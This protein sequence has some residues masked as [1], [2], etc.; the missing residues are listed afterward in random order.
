VAVAAEE[1]VE[2]L[3]E[4]GLEVVEVQVGDVEEGAV[5]AM[6]ARKSR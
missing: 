3:R 2:A 1:G 4:A 6:P 5:T